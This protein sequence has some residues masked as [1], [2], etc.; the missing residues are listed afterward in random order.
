MFPGINCTAFSLV[1]FPPTINALRVLS[2]VRGGAGVCRAWSGQGRAHAQRW[3]AYAFADALILSIY[4][5]IDGMHVCL[6]PVPRICEPRYSDQ[7]PKLCP[8][9]ADT[10]IELTQL[11]ADT[12]PVLACPELF[13]DLQTENAFEVPFEFYLAKCAP[14]FRHGE[15]LV[16]LKVQYPAFTPAVSFCTGFLV[17]KPSLRRNSAVRWCVNDVVMVCDVGCKTSS[18]L[19]MSR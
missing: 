17:V 13:S 15:A 12:I 5:F 6:R 11:W 4:S 18:A 2:G 3:V 19:R 14:G 9:R 7:L 10:I 8:T 1:C 16:V